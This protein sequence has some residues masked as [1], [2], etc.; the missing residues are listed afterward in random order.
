MAH[1]STKERLMILAPYPIHTLFPH[2]S[3]SSSTHSSTRVL[4]KIPMLLRA[5]MPARWVLK[6]IP[7][8]GEMTHSFHHSI[9]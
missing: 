9:D 6:I 1:S 4:K 7:I 2:S 3:T 5:H 8:L